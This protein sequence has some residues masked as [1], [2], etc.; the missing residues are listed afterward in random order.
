[1]VNS[2]KPSQAVDKDGKELQLVKGAFC[3]IIAGNHRGHYCEVQGLDDENCR[4]IVKTA[5]TNEILSLN[6][7]LI[8]LVN[9]EEFEKNSRVI[10]EFFVSMK[11]LLEIVHSRQRQV[12]GKVTWGKQENER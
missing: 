6:E 3:K 11:H 2:S 1:M 9:K 5:I 12:S 8:V 7:F 4:A 10:S